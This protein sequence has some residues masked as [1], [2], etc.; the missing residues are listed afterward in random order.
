[1]A[2]GVDLEDGE[3]LCVIVLVAVPVPDWV[4]D[5]VA[6]PEGVRVPVLLGDGCWELVRVTELVALCDGVND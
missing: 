3:E 2:L 4:W 5:D 1:M 6:A